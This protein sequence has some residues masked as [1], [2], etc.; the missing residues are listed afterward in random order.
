MTHKASSITGHNCSAGEKT[1]RKRMDQRLTGGNEHTD[2]FTL[3]APQN[4]PE[5]LT[6]STG[7]GLMGKWKC[8]EHERERR[9]WRKEEESKKKEEKGNRKVNGDSI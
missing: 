3:R 7:F 1:Q 2:V 6:V 5:S 4:S 9:E 8:E